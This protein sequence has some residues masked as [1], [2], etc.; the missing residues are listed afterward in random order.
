MV[1]AANI[2]LGTPCGPQMLVELCD[3]QSLVQLPVFSTDR[4][5]K[6]LVKDTPM[7]GR[8]VPRTPS[9][10]ACLRVGPLCGPAC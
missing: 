4:R 7:T 3:M 8:S 10:A 1:P 9:P 2:L 5:A 6:E